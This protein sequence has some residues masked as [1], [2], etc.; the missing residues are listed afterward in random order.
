MSDRATEHASARLVSIS[1]KFFY[2]S[3]AAAEAAIGIGYLEFT[4]IARH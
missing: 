1:T 3:G 2:G 4:H